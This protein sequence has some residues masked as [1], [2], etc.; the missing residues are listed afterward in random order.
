MSAIMEYIKCAY[1]LDDLSK[2]KYGPDTIIVDSYFGPTIQRETSESFS[3]LQERLLSLT[4]QVQDELEGLR[5]QFIT[6]QINAMLTQVDMGMGEEI[7]YHKQVE[8]FFDVSA[9]LISAKDIE[10]MQERVKNGLLKRG[11]K[12]DTTEEIAT[13]RKK[14]ELTGEI[15]LV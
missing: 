11:L 7:S 3:Q 14:Y 8:S 15:L 9:D 1:I 12:G 4:N 5:K 10:I 6:N 13:W 2:Q